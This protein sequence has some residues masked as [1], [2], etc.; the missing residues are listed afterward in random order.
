MPYGLGI[1]AGGTY[2]DAV[3]VEFS[4]QQVLAKV[5][6]LTTRD[7]LS[8]GVADAIGKLPETLLEHAQL[9]SLSTT[10][11]T[12]AIVEG[13][14]GKVGAVLLGFD[15][16][17]LAKVTHQPRRVVR[18]R[19]DITG[20][21]IEPL[22]EA[23]LREAVKQLLEYEAVDAIAVSG[24]M[25]VRNPS[26][27]RRAA[28]IIAAMTDKPVV[29]AHELSTQ[30]DSIKRTITACLNARLLPIIADLMTHVKATMAAHHIEAPLM[31]VRGDGTLMSEE[32]ARR[33]PVE[34]ILSGPAASVCGAR[35]LSGV[36]DGLVVDIGGTTSDVAV[37]IDGDPVVTTKGA[38]VADWNTI[39]RAVDIETVGLG[40]DSIIGLTKD[41]KLTIGP[42]RAIPLAYLADNC[43][44]IL[45]E[46]HRLWAM[47]DNRSA[48]VQP[49]ECFRLVRDT[50]SSDLSQNEV[51]VLEVLANGPRSREQLAEHLE[52]ID[53]SLVPVNRLET[54]GMIQRST[55]TPTDIMHIQGIYTAWN[56]EAAEIGLRIFAHRAGM[57][58]TVLAERCLDDFSNEMTLHLLH[59]VLRHQQ[60]ALPDFPQGPANRALL[61][62]LCNDTAVLG[63]SLHVQCEN[64]LIA[65][66]APA[67]VLAKDA[68]AR[69]GAELLVPE[70][71]EVANA[72]GAISG[73]L[74]LQLE[75]TIIPDDDMYVAHTP[76]ECREFDTLKAAQ[77]WASAAV[78]TLL[79]DRIRD[80]QVEGFTFHRTIQGV[81]R[82]GAL[83]TGDIFL[84]HR[85]RATAVGRPQFSGLVEA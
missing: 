68:A 69:L 15:E 60:P 37:L 50:I 46:L 63:L 74:T 1:D 59:R 71:A 54:L 3:I 13:K 51:R 75:A 18:G 35:V 16:Y 8:R 22:D 85:L 57:D 6:A 26:L 67:Q 30:L 84:E 55:L 82:F 80:A 38:C 78:E 2:T 58:P 9:V 62:L 56:R 76:L 33:T 27:E 5:K 47:R 53:P 41:G 43:P 19:S 10:L 28:D 70:H 66:G 12:N 31:V 42:R 79:E 14:G 48:L 17:D 7:D 24:M 81:D 73:V 77:E 29:C 64:P 49:V 20:K 36:Q 32:T 11:A 25:S 44:S 21:V 72:V 45:D 83:G 52:A 61:H 34:T 4:S 39:V 23:G 40:G 65:I